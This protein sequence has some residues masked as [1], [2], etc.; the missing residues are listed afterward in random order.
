MMVSQMGAKEYE[1]IMVISGNQMNYAFGV[2]HHRQHWAFCSN[3]VGESL[4]N[5][6]TFVKIRH[7]RLTLHLV[8]LLSIVFE[9][10][11]RL[12][13]IPRIE[14]E[15]VVALLQV[16]GPKHERIAFLLVVHGVM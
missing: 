5:R 8:L 1:Y 3:Q 14:L 16:T 9:C 15:D 7:G 2:N 4:E 10:V 13:V 6:L 11:V 12:H